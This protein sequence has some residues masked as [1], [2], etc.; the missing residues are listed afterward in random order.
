MPR[1]LIVQ[2]EDV[3]AVVT[4]VVVLAAMLSCAVIC[5]LKGKPG[6]VIGGIFI[7]IL[8]IVGA[9]RLA[10]PRSIWARRYYDADKLARSYERYPEERR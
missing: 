1:R 7:R 5:G 6:M 2:A 10:K 9:C 4:G 8:W 3:G